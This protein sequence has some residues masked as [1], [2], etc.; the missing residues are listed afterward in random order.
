VWNSPSPRQSPEQRL[1]P[2]G[3]DGRAIRF[4]TASEGEHAPRRWPRPAPRWASRTPWERASPT[5]GRAL[6]IPSATMCMRS[7]CLERPS[8]ARRKPTMRFRLLGWRHVANQVPDPGRPRRSAPSRPGSR[9][10][11]ELGE[12]AVMST[13]RSCRPGRARRP[14][15]PR[16]PSRFFVAPPPHADD[17]GPGVG[18]GECACGRAPARARQ[19]P[20]RGARSRR[21]RGGPGHLPGQVRPVRTPAADTR[22]KLR[23]DL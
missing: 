7:R 3:R 14:C 18:A 22:R 2:L 5:S 13:A 9:P 12:A 15:R 8:L 21:P 4:I 19:I 20:R 17:V 23:H 10:G 11:A 16:W 6:L 1:V